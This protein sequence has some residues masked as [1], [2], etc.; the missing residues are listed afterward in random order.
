MNERGSTRRRLG[1]AL[2]IA[3][4]LAV[5]AVAAVL[6]LGGRP[7]TYDADRFSFRHPGDWRRVEGVQF[8]LAQSAGRGDVGRNTVGTD[9]DN[10]VTVYTADVEVRVT[11]DNVEQLLGPTRQ[12]FD[13]L[14]QANPG[15]RVLQ[16]PSVVRTPSMAGVRVRLASVSPRGVP[17]ENEV[18]E[19]FKDTTAYIVGCQH[20]RDSGSAAMIREGCRQVVETLTPRR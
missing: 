20:R 18:I 13:E 6:L 19:L 4:G 5:V 16:P 8:L 9:A 15:V 7:E 11:G 14:A 12:V 10:W 17:V 1:L 2:G 3:V